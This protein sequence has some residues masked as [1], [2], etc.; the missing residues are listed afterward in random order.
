MPV[1][2]GLELFLKVTEHSS[3]KKVPF[4]VMSGNFGLG[5]CPTK[6]AWGKLGAKHTL[7]KPAKYGDIL[8]AVKDIFPSN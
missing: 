7:D 5:G 1:M 8:S 6:E 2:N 4:I 3:F